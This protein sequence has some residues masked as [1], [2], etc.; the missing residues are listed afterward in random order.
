MPLQPCPRAPHLRRL[1]AA[2]A[3]LLAPVVS[4]A[5]LNA[6]DAAAEA[7]QLDQI[8]VVGRSASG[9]YYADEVSGAKLD[10]PLRELPQAVRVLSRQAIDDLGALRLSDTL[11]YVGGVSRQNNFGGLWDNIALRGLPGNENTGGALLLNGFSANR[12]FNAPRDTADVE[13]FEFLKGPA[14]A[15]YG[16][17][18]PG[19]TVN[20]VS[21]RPLWQSATAL[22]LY[23]GSHDFQRAAFDSTGPLSESLA[24]RLNAAAEARDSFRDVVDQR[25]RLLAPALTWKLGLDT[26]LNYVGQWLEHEAVLDRGVPAINGQLGRVPIE[27][28]TGEPGDGHIRLRNANHQL[29]LDHML[30]DTWSL[31]GAL[32]AK[33]ASLRGFSTEPSVVEADGRTLRR[34]RRFRDYHSEDR[35]LQ[36][37]AIGRLQGERVSHELLLGI[38]LYDFELDQRMLRINPSASA[39]YA[40]DLFEPVYGQPLP[41][42]LPNTDTFERQRSTA[43]YLQEALSLGDRWRLVAAVRGERFRQDF[44][45]RRTSRS[46]AQSP[47][48][49][50]PR[51]GL[52][53]LGEGGFTVFVNVGDSFRP[54][55]GSD[56]DGRAFDPESGRSMEIGSKWERGDG[57]F[58]ATLTAFQIDK[59]NVLTGDPANAGFSIASGEVRSR[60]L[61][62]DASGQVGEHWRLNAS[63]VQLDA[64]VTRDNVLAVGSPL[65]NVPR[66]NGSLLA[67]YERANGAG[68]FGLGGGFTHVGER[69][70]ETRTRADATAGVELF[71]LPAYTT[72]KL[73]AYWRPNDRIGFSLDVD[74]VFDR[75]HY[76]SSVMRTWVTPGEARRITLGAQLRF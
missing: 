54:N 9:A 31:R 55:A 36:V 19:G 34:Q 11:D 68:L 44:S 71:R 69:A 52:S 5:P 6:V 65:I 39:P 38:E 17:S 29:A 40:I 35:A 30:N 10:L 61:E 24:W 21:K 47:T 64:E 3:C 62:F 13:R 53:W 28:F 18:E 66:R 42:P 58:G 37:E 7:A 15:L 20:V 48:E 1:S 45:N 25:R 41:T 72:A 2:I 43:L 70:G 59:R 12:G 74:N 67:V 23:A 32:S 46:S 56:V 75:E 76:I 33:D 63:W 8:E 14:S 27:R 60:G 73:V 51:L 49:W 26:E 4:A 57:G 16:S 22:E 50:V